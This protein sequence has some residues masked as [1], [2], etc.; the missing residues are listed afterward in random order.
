MNIRDQKSLRLTVYVAIAIFM[1]SLVITY[2][3]SNIDLLIPIISMY[4]NYKMLLLCSVLLLFTW[5]ISIF[6][7]RKLIDI[8]NATQIDENVTKK[9]VV[10]SDREIE[11]EFET[12]LSELAN[13][14]KSI[15]SEY[16]NK[17]VRALPFGFNNG[18]VRSLL[19]RNIFTLPSGPWDGWKDPSFSINPIAMRVLKRNQ[20]FLK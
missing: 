16:V 6:Y 17:N 3:M 15:L 7:Y 12:I 5:L 19:E 2:F 14:E 1:L 13:D 18:T 11:Q 9:N 20:R 10:K 8:I 4:L